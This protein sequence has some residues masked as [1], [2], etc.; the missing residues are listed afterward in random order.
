MIIQ[1][2]GDLLPKSFDAKIRYVTCAPVFKNLRQCSLISPLNFSFSDTKYS[3]EVSSDVISVKLPEME[4]APLKHP[5]SISFANRK[6]CINFV[7]SCFAFF[8]HYR[9]SQ[10]TIYVI[11]GSHGSWKSWKVFEF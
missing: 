6:V 11:Q 10:Y 9:Y 2:I 8:P 4:N 3:V 1:N 7:I 5:I